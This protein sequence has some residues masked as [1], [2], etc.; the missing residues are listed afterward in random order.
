M[1]C[2]LL[3]V[4]PSI[5]LWTGCAASSPNMKH[6]Q[7]L[8]WF[9][10]DG[11]PKRG[12]IGTVRQPCITSLT[13]HRPPPLP[14]QLDSCWYGP[15]FPVRIHTRALL[16]S[17]EH[18]PHTWTPFYLQLPAAISETGGFSMLWQLHWIIM[19][20]R[21]SRTPISLL[22]PAS[23]RLTGVSRTRF[24]AGIITIILWSIINMPQR[25][26]AGMAVRRCEAPLLCLFTRKPNSLNLTV[27]DTFD[28]ITREPS[29]VEPTREKVIPLGCK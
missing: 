16:V 15:Q 7:G 18:G 13:A 12:A 24:H 19:R 3:P 14:K 20:I 17:A 10:S 22:G 8:I 6:V 5:C 1:Q 25:L 9:A 2:P 26:S 4:G 11:L 27:Q 21:C 28:I 23:M 29:N